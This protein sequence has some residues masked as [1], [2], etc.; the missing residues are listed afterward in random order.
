[1][2]STKWHNWPPATTETDLPPMDGTSVWVRI[3]GHR[4]S[5]S[6]HWYSQLAGFV[7]DYP[8]NSGG[9]EDSSQ[10]TQWRLQ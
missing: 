4:G 5:Y 1:M 9:I 10:V 6:A 2:A 7:L 8:D 3:V